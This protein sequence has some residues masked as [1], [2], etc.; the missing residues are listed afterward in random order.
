MPMRLGVA[1]WAIVLLTGFAPAPLPRAPRSTDAAELLKKLQGTWEVVV[2]QDDLPLPGNS[3][4]L[5]HIE[6][7]SWRFQTVRG[8][9]L[10]PN[11]SALSYRIHLDTTSKPVRIDLQRQPR[12]A[13]RGNLV[14]QEAR[15]SAT[16]IYQGVIEL[17]GDT[18]RWCY[19]MAGGNREV[20]RPTSL[21][22]PPPGAVLMTL[23]RVQP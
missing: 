13:R 14:E 21:D 4:R 22:S 9:A 16:P 15:V 5:I 11:R 17:Q 6:G 2:H 3:R 10:Q 20:V 12:I 18:L 19:V 8:N 1:L 7:E 23:R